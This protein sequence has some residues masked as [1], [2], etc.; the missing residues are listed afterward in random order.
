[1]AYHEV[2]NSLE[3]EILEVAEMFN[4]DPQHLLVEFFNPG[5]Q[6]IF[7]EDVGEVRFRIHL[8]LEEKRIISVK[9]IAGPS[10][11]APGAPD[12]F[13]KYKVFMK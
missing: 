3:E 2:G 9:Q 4:F 11:R 12:P 10:E 13:E 7:V 8:S 1:M 5:R 6:G